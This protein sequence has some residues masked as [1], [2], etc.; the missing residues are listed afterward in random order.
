MC[1]S[2]NEHELIRLAKSGDDYAFELLLSNYRNLLT[3]ISRGYFLQNAEIEDLLQVAT[4]GFYLAVKSFDESK[5]VPFAGYA[6]TVIERK[7]INEIKRNNRKKDLP[8]DA[9]VS[10]SE[11]TAFSDDDDEF[12]D[13][14]NTVVKVD[15]ITPE[16]VVLENDNLKQ[17][18]KQIKNVLSQFE[19]DV[20]EYYLQGLSYNEIAAAI[21]KPVK[22][23][24]NAL[25]RIKE[26][27]KFLKPKD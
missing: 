23:V 7:V 19:L 26:K 3:S 20:L 16:E 8:M 11:Q 4:L 15:Y 24:D 22:S 6:K 14:G 2:V 27:L 9:Y 17:I 21:K 12:E 10:V 5:G 18:L 25:A 1:M 13:R